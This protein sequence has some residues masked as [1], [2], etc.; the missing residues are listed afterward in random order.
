[1]KLI[2]ALIVT[3]LTPAAAM[4]ADVSFSG[5]V[6]AWD[7]KQGAACESVA[8]QSVGAE[9]TM[10]AVNGDILVSLTSK[11]W[12]AMEAGRA[13]DVSFD[14]GGERLETRMV[15]TRAVDGEMSLRADAMTPRLRAALVGNESVTVTWRGRTLARVSLKGGAAALDRLAGC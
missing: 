11:R 15:A 4:A 9:M 5:R 14:F 6:G 8:S 7:A 10:A 3:V 1:M 13:F 2:V 12:R